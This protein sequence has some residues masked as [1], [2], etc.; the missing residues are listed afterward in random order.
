MYS[1]GAVHFLQL[2]AADSAFSFHIE[3]DQRQ[4]P[5]AVVWMTGRH[6]ELASRYGQV[7]FT[8]GKWGGNNKYGLFNSR[9][10]IGRF[11]LQES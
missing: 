7:L 1:Y 9:V 8:D 6:K 3:R 11:A 5:T 4:A 10:C 2:A